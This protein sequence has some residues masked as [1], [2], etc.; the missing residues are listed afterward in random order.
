LG[1]DSERSTA[2]SLA[3]AIRFGHRFE[4]LAPSP[5]PIPGAPIQ[6]ISDWRRRLYGGLATAAGTVAAVGGVALGA[7]AAVAGTLTAA[8]A[9]VAGG[10]VAGGAIAAYQGVQALRRPRTPAH[11]PLVLPATGIGE[12]QEKPARFKGTYDDGGVERD[13]SAHHK[14]PYNSIRATANRAVSGIP[15]PGR[16]PEAHEALEAWAQ[17]DHEGQIGAAGAAWTDHN[18]FLGPAPELRAHDPGGEGVDTHFT[19]SGTVTPRSELALDVA[20]AG[21]IHRL[22]PEELSR[23]LA[24]LP[25][26]SHSDYDPA[27]WRNTPEG[28]RQRGEPADWHTRSLA[29][30]RS[31]A[32]ARRAAKNAEV[33]AARNRPRRKKNRRR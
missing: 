24:A 19:R 7:S 20:H 9:L 32:R 23:R 2:R 14:V 17:R 3:S 33:E 22:D 16:G 28:L 10:L 11:N 5:S 31:Y 25:S 15:L 27:E 12:R 1:L 30:K 26:R 8:P 29:D 13:L 4:N 21:G 18:I 6:R